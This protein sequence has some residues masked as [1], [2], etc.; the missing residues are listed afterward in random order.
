LTNY[1]LVINLNL[2]GGRSPMA[3]GMAHKKAK[4]ATKKAKK[5]C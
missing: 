3:C 5:K 2:K 4:K 1:A